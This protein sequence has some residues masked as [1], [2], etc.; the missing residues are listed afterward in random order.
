M[1]KSYDSQEALDRAL[2]NNELYGA[3][4]V[5]ADFSQSQYDQLVETMQEQ[6]D[7]M[8]G[9]MSDMMSGST[10]ASG[11]S[12]LSSLGASSATPSLSSEA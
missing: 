8:Q 4:V 6:I 11:L 3:I 1:W 12:S 10:P 2:A 5:P 9:S 7:N